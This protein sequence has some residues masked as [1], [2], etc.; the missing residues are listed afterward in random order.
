MARR[1]AITS[2]NARTIDILNTIR[3]NASYE[4]QSSV[5]AVT[6]EK[7][8]P[9]VGEV[10][11]G[12][13]ALANQFLNALI[14]RIAL[15]K[16]KSAVFNNAYAELKKGYLEFGETVEEV[17][18]NIAKAREFSAEKAE[19]REFKRT[20]P[21]VRSAFHTMNW[22]VQY[23]VTIQNEDLRMAFTSIGGVEDLIARIVDS[24]YTAAEYDEFLLFKYLIIKAVSHGK[25]FPVPVDTSDMKNAAKKFRGFSNQ[26]TF[27]SNKYN[28]SAVT[29]TTPKEDQ[30]IFMDAQYN[31]NYDVDVL[32]SAFN[33]DK[34]TFMG[35]LKLIDDFTSF[36][37]DRF[38]V[39]RANSDMIEEVTDAEL[40]LMRDVKAVLV[41]S[42]WFQVYDNANQFTEQYVASGMYWNYF[43]NVWK[44]VSSSPFSNAI[45]FVD[46]TADTTLPNTLTVKVTDK[47]KAAEATILTLEPQISSATLEDRNYEFIQTQSCV[48]NLIAVHKYGA[49]I[50]PANAEAQYISFKIGDVVYTSN[51]QIGTTADVG[52]TVTFTRNDFIDATLSALSI[53][54]VTLT[55]SFDDEV[56][57]YTGATSSASGVIT[58][59]AT[60]SDATVVVK[61]NGTKVTGTTLSFASGAGNVL[62]VEVTGNSEGSVV[63]NIYKVTITRS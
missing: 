30:Y 28:A 61:M 5:P 33:M 55:P 44:T 24:I 43:F 18:V 60:D 53:T 38:N 20:L 29:T 25:M 45:V 59:T 14:N 3:A 4:Y 26:L 22:R 46:S 7:D 57:T 35:K 17:F 15:V 42:E 58:A 63:T 6:S 19:S 8:I 12:Y 50:Y 56:L 39:I 9:K 51:S 16:V 10:L 37:N 41:D 34:A 23:P 21:D 49:V 31:A 36:D 48:Q 1:V 52:D 2:L 13:P 32:A 47:N 40:A 27:M 62:T 11:Y 54:N